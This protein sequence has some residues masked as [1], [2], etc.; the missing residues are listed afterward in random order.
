MCAKKNEILNN[1]NNEIVFLQSDLFKNFPEY[2][3]SSFNIIIFNPPYLPS[4]SLV[5]ENKNEKKIDHSWN[6]GIKGYEI[7]I[8]FI[9]EARIFLNF[10]KAHYIYFISSNRTNLDEL[11]KQINELG[12]ENEIVEKK[13]IFFEDILLNRI[14]VI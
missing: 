6:G 1:F 12:F 5:N 9:K 11:N 13:H 8:D 7:I 4:S 3:K 10:K 2:L 14:K